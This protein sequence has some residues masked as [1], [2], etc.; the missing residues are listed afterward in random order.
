MLTISEGPSNV[1]QFNDATII[2]KNFGGMER[3]NPNKPSEIL[4]RAGDRNFCICIGDYD[5]NG[6]FVPNYDIADQLEA[7][8]FTV[9]KKEKINKFGDPVDFLYIKVNVKYNKT[10]DPNGNMTVRGPKIYLQSGN[11]TVQLTEET[12]GTIDN[13][14][15]IGCD[16]DIRPH[17]WD[18]SGKTG[19]SAYLRA[20]WIKQDIDRFDERFNDMM[21]GDDTFE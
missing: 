3:R 11:N 4:N 8:G 5:E 12:A 2:F 18:V 16:I 1:I 13:I 17:H 7:F 19:T 6:N 15:V 9:K 20:I 10:T 14:R 21:N